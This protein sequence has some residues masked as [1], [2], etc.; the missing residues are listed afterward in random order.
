MTPRKTY[1][2]VH[3]RKYWLGFAAAFLTC[4]C[5]RAFIVGPYTSDTNTLHLWH[6]DESTVPAVDSA[7]NGT[8]LNL[9]VLGFNAT[10]GNA[11]FTGFGSA[12][13]TGVSN[14]SYLA[15]SQIELSTTANNVTMQYADPVTG[16]FT[17]EAVVRVDFDPA[18]SVGNIQYSIVV[19]ENDGSEPRMFYLR[20]LPIGSTGGGLTTQVRLQFFN[21]NGNGNLTLP[22]PTSGPDAIVQGNWYHVAATWDGAVATGGGGHL[23][24]YWTLMDPSRAAPSLLGTGTMSNLSPIAGGAPEFSIGNHG[25]GTPA[26]ANWPGLIDEVR[27][28]K[29]ARAAT[30]MM[31]YSFNVVI[32]QDPVSQALAVGQ[33][34]SFSIVAAG[35]PPLHYQWR[36]NGFAIPSATN[37]AY[38]LSSVQLSDAA[39]YDVVVTNSSSTATSGVATLTVRVPLS[40]TWLGTAAVTWDTNS[41]NWDSNSDALAD[42]VFTYGDNVRF[43]D[44]G[45][46]NSIIDVSGT[47][48]PSSVVVSNIGLNYYLGTSGSGSIAGSCG[49]TKQGSGL[50]T[51]DINNT[52]AGPTIIQEG[53]LTVGNNDALGSLGSGPVINLGVLDFNR[54]DTVVV[55][56]NIDGSGSLVKD[57]AGSLRL[58]GSNTMSGTITQNKGNITVG[59]AGLGNCT[60]FV[61]MASGGANG[62]SFT[63]SGGTVVGANVNFSGVT[64][65]GDSG[66]RV[67]LSTES[68][69]N[70]WNGPITVSG[71]SPVVINIA[72][73][74]TL[75]VNGPITGP[76]FNN[77]VSFRGA[78]QSNCVIR[79]QAT[80]PTG[81]LQKDDG[82]I[83][84][85]HS[86]NNAYLFFRM[87]N[88]TLAL[89]N[90]NALATNCFIKT[91]GGTLDLAGFNQSVAGL[92][93]Y[94]A[95][96]VTTIANSSTNLDSRLTV[97]TT[98]ADAPWIS[99]CVIAD[100][101]GGGTRKTSL[102]LTGGATLVLTN[103]S[104]YS[105]DTTVAAGTLAL[106]GAGAILNSTPIAL[107]AGTTLDASARADSTLTVGVAQVLKG[108]RAFNVV[109]NLKN[110]GTIELKISKAGATLSNDSING[111]AT[112]TYGGTLKLDVTASPALTTSDSF[113][114][115]AA[116]SYEGAFASISPSVPVFGLAWDTS[117][118]ATDGTL[119]IKQGPA[120]TSTSI[121]AVVVGGGSALQIAWPADHLGWSLQVQTNAAGAGL[122]TNWVRVSGSDTVTQEVIPFDPASGSL[123]YRLIYP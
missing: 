117:T 3:S 97:I 121:T 20:L 123:F 38:N 28:S 115:F 24:L 80:L 1:K 56:N 118:L 31:F 82:I 75:E 58:M 8:N 57:A 122:S 19:T 52:F 25:R 51:L 46:A 84:T 34:A 11:S 9:T 5:A 119:R 109:G 77:V 76:S 60:N 108:D 15:A 70:I 67:N 42:S 55:N 17:V 83:W 86:S 26:R 63:L 48:T 112:V 66:N 37:S 21:L 90:D 4:F 91:D 41:V 27:I 95:T 44:N 106:S 18:A 61:M 78:A 88:G 79:S 85:L 102:T 40:L 30:N 59:P 116:T 53:T 49:L 73:G 71:D 87:L 54:T 6:L 120:T 107:A 68:G 74:S 33:P 65:G 7:N 14:A 94:R 45:S 81:G 13:N 105:G 36:T 103:A 10:L 69:S 113:K 111:A 22:V 89:G 99:G 50:L 29:I 43:D 39:S 93:N 100:S 114:L 16:A 35:S 62:T 110:N 104:T 12:L 72:A 98:P 64:S 92:A 32:S 2:N 23:N 101:T 96:P 47:F